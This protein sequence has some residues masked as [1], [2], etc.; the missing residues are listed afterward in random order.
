[1]ATNNIF[2]K[3][4]ITNEEYELLE[5]KFGNLANFAAWQLKRKNVKNNTTD[6]FDDF[7]QDLRMSIVCAGS[8]YK[9]QVYIEDCL[10]IAKR[11]ARDT[12][13]KSVLKELSRLWKD[14]TRHGASRQKFGEHQEDILEQIVEKIVPEH[15]RP[16]R[17]RPLTIDKRFP[18]YCKNV[19]W[20]KQKSVGRK[21]SRERTIRTG[22]VSLSEFDYLSQADSPSFC[23]EVA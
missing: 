20:N 7:V 11:F 5:A 2:Q 14:R 16:K 21:I 10:T 1:M 22:L 15:L 4:P 19:I 23:S 18:T 12:F 13:T 6:E 3:F 8:Y 17:N 9:R